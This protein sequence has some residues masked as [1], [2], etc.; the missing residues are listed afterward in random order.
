MRLKRFRGN[1]PTECVKQPHVGYFASLPLR[2]CPGLRLKNQPLGNGLLPIPPVN[3]PAKSESPR[4]LAYMRT[5]RSLTSGE[6]RFALLILRY[7]QE[8]ES[9]VNP[10]RFSR[11]SLTRL[12]VCDKA[13][14][15]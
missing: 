4:A 10:A 3:Y 15:M 6:Y 14:L 5:A 2:K 11:H 1:I 9:P 8:L 12:G 7:S 13:T